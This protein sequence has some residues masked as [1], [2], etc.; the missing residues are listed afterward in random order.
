[1]DWVQSPE[2]RNEILIFTR[3]SARPSSA[4]SRVSGATTDGE[5]ATCSS[6]ED[7][8][9]ASSVE[10]PKDMGHGGNIKTTSA[11]HKNASRTSDS[12]S[13]STARRSAGTKSARNDWEGIPARVCSAV[14]ETSGLS[15]EREL[16]IPSSWIGGNGD[17]NHDEI[18]LMRTIKKNWD[19][20]H[21]MVIIS[22][23]CPAGLCYPSAK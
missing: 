20:P 4:T 1:M 18:K 22:I 3:V 8:L 13:P 12:S 15:G 9:R 10:Q 21:Q 14:T 19:H 6:R 11:L 23:I 7:A 5:S 16:R 17:R 2:N